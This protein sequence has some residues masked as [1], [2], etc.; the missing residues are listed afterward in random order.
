MSVFSFQ[1]ICV[2]ILADEKFGYLKPFVTI[3]LKFWYV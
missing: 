3:S 1:I 2:F